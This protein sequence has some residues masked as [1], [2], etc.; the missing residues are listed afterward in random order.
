VVQRV[1]LVALVPLSYILFA[2]APAWATWTLLGLAAAAALSNPRRTFGGRSPAPLID[3]AIAAV[4]AAVAVQ[5]VP[6]PAGLLAWLSPH[7]ETVRREVDLLAGWRGLASWRPLTIEQRAT[8]IAL[9]TVVLAGL[10]YRTALGVFAAGGVRSW[11]RLL[12]RLGALAAIVAA[13]QR[14]IDPRALLGVVRVSGVEL[15]FGAF[16]NRNHF[17]AWL[18]MVLMVSGGYLIAHARIHAA[19]ARD[20]RGRI[21]EVLDSGG[22]LTAVSLGAILLVLLLTLSRSAAI[23]LGAAAVTSWLL[24]RDRV[25]LGPR[26]WLTLAGFAGVGLLAFVLFVDID[27]WSARLSSTAVEVGRP[28]NRLAIWRETLPMVRDF[29]LTGTG[30]GTYGTGI[31]LYQ[32]SRIWIPHLQGWMHFNQAHSQYLQVAAEGGVLVGAPALAGLLALAFAVVRAVR[33]DRGEIF[34]VRVGAASGLAGLA[35]QSVWETALR[36]PANAVL[37]AALVAVALH[38]RENRQQRDAG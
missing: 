18:L 28:Q 14:A 19:A 16:V 2:G 5:L 24:A 13:V 9:A 34:W 3:L 8:T 21:R 11:C 35:A 20:W 17:A 32:E 27:Q 29:W 25:E 36:M 31:L 15:P 33:R 38:G 37:G 30:A 6:L 1:L 10:T 22:L 7:E 4:V 12:A 26:P 23:G